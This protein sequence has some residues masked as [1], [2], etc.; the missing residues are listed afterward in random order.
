[1]E[2]NGKELVDRVAQK[3]GAKIAEHLVNE[4]FLEAQIA[5]LRASTKEETVSE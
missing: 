4:A 1:M 3:A 2:I 5:R